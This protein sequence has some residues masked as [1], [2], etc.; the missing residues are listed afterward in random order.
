MALGMGVFM[1]VMGVALLRAFR[2]YYQM[3]NPTRAAQYLRR[4]CYGKQYGDHDPM[5]PVCPLDAAFLTVQQ[6]TVEAC[7]KRFQKCLDDCAVNMHND[8]YEE[9]TKCL[10]EICQENP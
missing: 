8:T 2:S 9:L 3:P 5:C 1:G 4:P 6:E 10:S 7:A